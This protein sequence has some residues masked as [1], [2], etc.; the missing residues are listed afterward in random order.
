MKARGNKSKKSQRKVRCGV[1]LIAII[2][3][4]VSISTCNVNNRSQ[5]KEPDITIEELTV[6]STENKGQND[7]QETEES[8]R[9]IQNKDKVSENWLGDLRIKLG[10]NEIVEEKSKIKPVLESFSVTTK[11]G[12]DISVSENETQEP[13]TLLIP[14]PEVT[15]PETSPV[16]NST[17]EGSNDSGGSGGAGGS[18]WW[19][20]IIPEPTKPAPTEPEPTKPEPTKPEQTQPEPTPP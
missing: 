19:R 20:P 17:S 8:K 12:Q 10:N 11:K 14:E 16:E 7:Q 13:E 15:I 4:V 9:T 5:R 3:L 6:I 18:S 2:L 1:A